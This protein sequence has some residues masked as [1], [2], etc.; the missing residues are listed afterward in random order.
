MG[1]VSIVVGVGQ[2]R[3]RMG[4][5]SSQRVYFQV[6]NIRVDLRVFLRCLFHKCFIFYG[7]VCQSEWKL[8]HAYSTAIADGEGI[9]AHI[10]LKQNL[11]IVSSKLWA[12]KFSMEEEKGKN[13]TRIHLSTA[14]RDHA[15]H[16]PIG[17]YGR[18]CH[19]DLLAFITASSSL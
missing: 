3:H 15:H 6:A 13:A 5:A 1:V 18:K 8:K 4:V 10:Q 12:Q 9:W 7:S 2:W 19:W 16:F 11:V 17:L 14:L